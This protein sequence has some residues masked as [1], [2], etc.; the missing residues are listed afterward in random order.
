MQRMTPE[1]IKFGSPLRER[2]HRRLGLVGEGPQA[3]YR[4]ALRLVTGPQVESTTHLVS[5]LLREI[6]SALRDVLE[7]I[8]HYEG[9]VKAKG[10]Q[11]QEQEVRLILGE[12]GLSETEGPGAGWL[13]IVQTGLHELAH[14]RSLERP[15]PVDEQFQ[16]LW[17]EM[18]VVLDAVLERFESRFL[19]L[20]DEA[21]R[22][23]AKP[24]PSKADLKYLK[25]YLPN[26]S[27]TR[28]YFFNNLQH[29]GWLEPLADAGFFSDPPA[30]VRDAQAGTIS[31]VP[32][33]WTQRRLVR[34]LPRNV[35]PRIDRSFSGLDPGAN[36]V[37]AL[38]LT[39]VEQRELMIWNG[40]KDTPDSL[41]GA[42]FDVALPG[43]VPVPAPLFV[44]PQHVAAQLRGPAR[45]LGMHRVVE[46]SPAT[47]VRAVGE[48]DFTH[49]Q[50]LPA[51]GKIDMNRDVSTPLFSTA[52]SP[53]DAYE[54][55]SIQIV[56]S[57]LEFCVRTVSDAPRKPGSNSVTYG[58]AA[59]H[60][61]VAASR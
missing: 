27:V 44:H 43:S 42:R 24:V 1:P 41:A 2:I 40:V 22:L 49:A 21:D 8:A 47:H 30:A 31:L 14:R 57:A 29:D 39:L 60:T 20:H 48:D 5:H 16:A 45:P 53:H 12:L 19:E 17:A 10:T 58:D 51:V 26:N 13:E 35:Q 54:R 59:T 25:D 50:T 4:D 7:P 11:T 55:T 34:R 61:I 52:S 6:E 9:R 3:F 36:S 46:E 38:T 56:G 23:L 33:I 15:R 32:R 28:H 18:E 37:V